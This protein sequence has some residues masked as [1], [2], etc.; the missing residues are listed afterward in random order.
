MSQSKKVSFIKAITW[1][2]IDLLITA[3]AALIITGDL[4]ITGQIVGV[5]TVF[6]I[7]AYYVHERAWIKYFKK[8]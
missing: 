1:R 4:K 6:E 8:R 7:I 3:I 2:V 5:V